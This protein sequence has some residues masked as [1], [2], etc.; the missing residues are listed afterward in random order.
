[1]AMPGSLDSMMNY[2]QESAAERAQKSDA[3]A[4]LAEEG[5]D[6][7]NNALLNGLRAFLPL[8]A[9]GGAGQGGGGGGG[10]VAEPNTQFYRDLKLLELQDAHAALMGQGVNSMEVMA[11]VTPS[12]VDQMGGLGFGFKIR[13][14]QWLKQQRIIVIKL[15]RQ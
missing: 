12:D 13:L 3:N 15:K 5:N 8:A 10:G 1:M 4:K 14:K 11:M 2:L 6:K 9:G 7:R